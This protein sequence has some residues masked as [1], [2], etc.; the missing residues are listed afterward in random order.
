MGVFLGPKTRKIPNVNN[1]KITR[2]SQ[3]QAFPGL[4]VHVPSLPLWEL[5]SGRGGKAQALAGLA[6][7][8]PSALCELCKNVLGPS[9]QRTVVAFLFLREELLL[10]SLDQPSLR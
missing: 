9:L 7:V 10:A 2:F 5:G 3:P 6:G 8:G 1:P 4:A